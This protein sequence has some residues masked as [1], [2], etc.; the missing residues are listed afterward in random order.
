M[1]AKRKS[2]EPGEAANQSTAKKSMFSNKWVECT[3]CGKRRHVNSDDF[4]GWMH[5]SHNAI[6]GIQDKTSLMTC[7]TCLDDLERQDEL[8]W[9]T[10]NILRLAKCSNDLIHC[11]SKSDF[12][13]NQ[14]TTYNSIIHSRHC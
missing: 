9:L 13:Y 6:P 8:S 1:E 14:I 3:S 11:G 7:Q 5:L 10:T 2:P 12:G 4:E